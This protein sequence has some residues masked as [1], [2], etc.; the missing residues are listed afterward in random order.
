MLSHMPDYLLLKN[1]P[2]KDTDDCDF[3]ERAVKCIKDCQQHM[4][5]I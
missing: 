5:P 3:Y 4:S 2:S 1:I